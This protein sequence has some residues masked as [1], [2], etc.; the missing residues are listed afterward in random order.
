VSSSSCSI[1]CIHQ[2]TETTAAKFL[3][4]NETLEALG[5]HA[6]LQELADSPE[7]AFLGELKVDPYEARLLHAAGHPAPDTALPAFLQQAA[8]NSKLLEQSDETLSQAKDVCLSAHSQI[9]TL[10]KEQDKDPS[11]VNSDQLDKP[12]PKKRKLYTGLGKLFSGAVLLTGDAICIP[13][14][15]MVPAGAIPIAGSLA[16]GMAALGA[17]I[18]DL[19][20]E[21]CT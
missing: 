19:R 2:L 18:G 4:L 9:I 14:M 8:A 1:D 15:A 3:T 20:G 6:L 21:G 12:N 10:Q 5:A 16:G 7:V 11:S 13:G 17:G